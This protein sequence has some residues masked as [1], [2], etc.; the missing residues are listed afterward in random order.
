MHFSARKSAHI[1]ALVELEA[2]H[3]IDSCCSVSY[4]REVQGQSSA[5]YYTVSILGIARV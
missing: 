3:D 4:S 5:P 1:R 2:L